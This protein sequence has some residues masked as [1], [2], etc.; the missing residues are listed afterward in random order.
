MIN[1]QYFVN[2]GS[3]EIIFKGVI[4][5]E[6]HNTY[7]ILNEANTDLDKLDK[8][9]QYLDLQIKRFCIQYSDRNPHKIM[10]YAKKEIDRFQKTSGKQEISQLKNQIMFISMDNFITLRVL[11][12]EEFNRFKKVD[13]IIREI[14]I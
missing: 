8:L 11:S 2:I 1:K 4:L 13:K 6:Q 7:I 9:I 5:F 12:E 10:E 14:I 3:Q